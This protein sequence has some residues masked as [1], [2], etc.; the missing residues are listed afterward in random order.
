MAR[1]TAR[2]KGAVSLALV[3]MRERM[4]TSVLAQELTVLFRP[5]K[6]EYQVG[7]PVLLVLDLVNEGS[8]AV[9]RITST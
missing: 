4:G 2:R 9:V 3:E 1:P 7:K 8:Q 5:E 6:E